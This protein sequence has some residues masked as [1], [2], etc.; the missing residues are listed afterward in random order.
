MVNSS[1]Y[2]HGH[3]KVTGYTDQRGWS[4]VKWLSV[5]DRKKPGII[6]SEA[7]IIVSCPLVIVSFPKEVEQ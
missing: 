6:V 5:V 1:W 2:P 4:G 7:H 3:Q